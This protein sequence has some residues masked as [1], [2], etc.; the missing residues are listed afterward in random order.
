[1]KRMVVLLLWLAVAAGSG[2][3]VAGQQLTPYQQLARD[4]LAQL[5]ELRSTAALPANTRAAATAMAE[6]LIDAGFAEADVRVVSP[7]PKLG[8]LVARYRGRGP[9]GG[10]PRRRPIL[11]MA[12]LDVVDALRSDWSFDPFTFRQ[13]DGFFYGRG[14]D[15]NKAGAAILVAN[16]I[17]FRQEGFIPNRDL[18]IALTGDEETSS[19]SI[20]Y[21]VNDRRDLVD[22]AFALNSDAGGGNLKDG[23]PHLFGVQAAEKV[24]LTFRL[25][26]RNPG[27]HSSR[28]RP[29][30]AI[31][32]LTMG[33]ARLSEFEFPLDLN[34]VTRTYF[35]RSAEFE[36]GQRAADMGAV[37]AQ[38]PNPE[39][40]ARLSR[41]SPFY[42]AL[43]HTTCVATRLDAGHADN[44]L[45]QT[46]RATVNCRIL[47]G[48]SPDEVEK[49]LD[50]VLGDAEIAVTR[51]NQ[52]TPS[53]P[54]PLVPQV[55]GPIERIVEQMWPGVPVIPSMST[56]A[57]DGLYVRNAGI[58]VYGVSAIFSDPDDV[59][60]H[61]RD[62]RVGVKEFFDA[63]EFW[64]RMLK[65]LA[66]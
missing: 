37:A 24:Y 18:I 27:G 51:V 39:A 42:N 20:R 55:M 52:P 34:E 61:G 57:T 41:S 6:R 38:P 25:E 23:K 62:E 49:T 45:P 17:R 9:D 59:R 65:A 29:D 13:L 3:L 33:L 46:A 40:A 36:S 26:V 63:Y 14:T 21:L 19:A 32:T 43:L 4:I 60:A 58:P 8:S 64:Y 50:Q 30:N 66:S 31:Y 1:M 44:A 15:D 56:G 54:S 2:Q 11:L 12:H 28:P 22:A 48:Q 53:P 47:P 35:E 10:A 7:D 5:V 16:F